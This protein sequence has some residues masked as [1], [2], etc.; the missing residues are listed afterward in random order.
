MLFFF[1]SFLFVSSLSSLGSLLG[2]LHAILF[3]V[4]TSNEAACFLY[5]LNQVTPIP[6]PA[7]AAAM[8]IPANSTSPEPNSHAIYLW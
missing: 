1:R 4:I 3:V 5:F 2:P 8:L 6:V 7:N